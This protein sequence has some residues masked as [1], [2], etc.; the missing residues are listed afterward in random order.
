MHA[1]SHMAKPPQYYP[2]QLR[3]LM[4]YTI[5]QAKFPIKN[6]LVFQELFPPNNMRKKKII[7]YILQFTTKILVI[8]SK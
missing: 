5:E 4:K 7:H 6:F 2:N 8:T 1:I 3:R